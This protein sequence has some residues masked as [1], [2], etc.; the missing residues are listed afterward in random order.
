MAKLTLLCVILSLISIVVGQGCPT[1][2]GVNPSPQP[3]SY[4][5]EYSASACCTNNTEVSV[6]TAMAAAS[7]VY[8]NTS[9]F[10]NFRDYTCAVACSPNQGKF[11]NL[12]PGN[13]TVLTGYLT[14]DFAQQ[15]YQ[16]CKNVCI[17]AGGVTVE[18]YTQANLTTFLYLFSTDSNPNYHPSTYV[19]RIVFNI[20]NYPATNLTYNQTAHSGNNNFLPCPQAPPTSAVATTAALSS[21]VGTTT[22]VVGTTHAATTPNAAPFDAPSILFTVALAV[23]AMLQCHF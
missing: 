6:I 14:L 19:P 11:V 23:T 13:P 15:W 8:G 2:F 12:V 17:A 9:C 4:C 1:L 16:S 20:G 10:Q 7:L 5:T 3:L 18:L 22:P 21:T